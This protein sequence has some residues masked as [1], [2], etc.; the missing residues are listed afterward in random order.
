MEM[1]NTD[2]NKL[3]IENIWKK[4]EIVPLVFNR[5]DTDTKRFSISFG[6]KL[7]L[8]EVEEIFMLNK[9]ENGT[10]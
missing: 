6:K 10:V 2:S 3:R 9:K 1:P 7:E 5:T 4:K 8:L